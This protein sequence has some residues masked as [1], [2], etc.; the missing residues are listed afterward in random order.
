MGYLRTIRSAL[1]AA[2]YNLVMNGTERRCLSDWR[3][4]LLTFACGE[5][6]EIGAGTGLN[7]P[8]YAPAVTSLTLSEP[9]HHMRKK[10]NNTV[11]QQNRRVQIRDWTAEHVIMPDN[12]YDTIVSTL[13]LC[14]VGCQAHSLGEIKRLL[15]PGGQLIFMEHIRSDNPRVMHWQKRLEPTWRLCAGN[16]RLTRDTLTAIKVAGLSIEA[17][18]EAP[19][20]GTPAFVSRT[21]R[22]IARKPFSTTE[23]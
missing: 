11:M 18:T 12:F 17:V 15:K 6:L 21:I 10:L 22:G 5:V 1:I 13:V 16:C 7:I 2:S 3:R 14:S 4:E 8:Y 9:D 19:M 23:S 20:L